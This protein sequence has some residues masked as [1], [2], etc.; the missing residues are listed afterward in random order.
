MNS[1]TFVGNVGADVEV[2]DVNTKNGTK[3]VAEFT[4]ADNQGKDKEPIWWRC[5][6]WEDD[7]N[8]GFVT[9]SNDKG[10]FVKKGTG[11]VVTG[12]VEQSEKVKNSEGFER[13][14]MNV[15]VHDMSYAGGLSGSKS[16]SSEGGEKSGDGSW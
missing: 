8:F 14:F 12:R 11:L 10:S 16:E 9:G 1:I 6:I 5:S 4:V 13:R 3:K 7:R 2:K 15:R